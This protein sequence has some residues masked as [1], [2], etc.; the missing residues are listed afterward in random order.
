M[1]VFLQDLYM[2][3]FGRIAHVTPQQ[4]GVKCHL[5]VILGTWTI[6]F[7]LSYITLQ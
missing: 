2:I 1:N 5:G 3:A 4:V 6:W 7:I